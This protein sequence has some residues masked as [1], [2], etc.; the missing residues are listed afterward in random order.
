[1]GT[2]QCHNELE[3]SYFCTI[4]QKWKKFHI[5]MDEVS[6]DNEDLWRYELD[7]ALQE[8]IFEIERCSIRGVINDA[9]W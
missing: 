7:K 1:M 6:K 5:S 3:V 9:L 8:I 2:S 4:D